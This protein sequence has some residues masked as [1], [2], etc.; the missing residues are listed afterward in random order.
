MLDA[1]A[2]K[3]L[4]VLVLVAGGCERAGDQSSVRPDAADPAAVD[5]RAPLV[6][7]TRVRMQ[8]PPGG[9]RGV[10]FLGYAWPDGASIVVVELP[11]PYSETS[12]GLAED[13]LTG[14]GMTL[15]GSEAVD[16]GGRAAQL[17]H[18]SQEAQGVRYRKWLLVLGDE[19]HTIII[20]AIYPEMLAIEFTE[21]F[22]EALLSAS[23]D[24][25][26]VVDPRDELDWTIEPPQ[27]LELARGPM[28]ALLFTRGGQSTPDDHG[29]PIYIAG[30]SIG[31]L[32]VEDLQAQAE[33][34]VSELA[35][36]REL[37]I[38]LSQRLD[39]ATTEAWE[40]VARAKDLST[41]IDLMVHQVM[42]TTETGYVRMVGMVGAADAEAWLPRFREAAASWKPRTH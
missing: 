19:A 18:V 35:Q 10:G 37:E 5:D 15:L 28:G 40:I 17:L 2:T 41:G 36:V 24:P 6:P 1:A 38:E 34:A 4:M 39:L 29:A 20:S 31:Y 16:A 23:W 25:S 7:G 22:R 14:Q 42:L 3:L 32:V 26:V 27:G 21:P 11:A 33:A 9:Q 8:V 30:A 12:K 13:R